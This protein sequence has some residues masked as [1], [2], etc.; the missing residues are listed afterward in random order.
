MDPAAAASR[1]APSVGRR[2]EL[3][4]G[5]TKRSVLVRETGGSAIEGD[6]ESDVGMEAA[7]AWHLHRVEHGFDYERIGASLSEAL[8]RAASP[9]SQPT[10]TCRLST[11]SCGRFG[12]ITVMD[13]A[14]L[15]A[16]QIADHLGHARPSMTQ[17]LYMGR[18]VATSRAAEVL[19]E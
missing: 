11:A 4:D 17:D 16:R 8:A 15:S 6:L 2:L 14:G 18:N 7:A 3:L 12:Q 5:F 10:K 9:S 19:G 13:E 1:W